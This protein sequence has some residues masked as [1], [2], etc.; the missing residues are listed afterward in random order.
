MSFNGLEY[1]FITMS[2]QNLI[3]K[4]KHSTL[5]DFINFSSFRDNFVVSIWIMHSVLMMKGGDI[6]LFQGCP[7]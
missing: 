4:H 7:L 1:S 3:V 2:L 5:M 6:I